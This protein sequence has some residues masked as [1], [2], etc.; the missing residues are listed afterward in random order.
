MSQ[1]NNVQPIKKKRI[2]APRVNRREFGGHGEGGDEHLWA[3]SYSDLL[4]VLMSFFVIYFSFDSGEKAKDGLLNIAVAMKGQAVVD[5]EKPKPKET[6]PAGINGE[7][8]KQFENMNLRIDKPGNALVI[9]LEPDIFKLGEF[10]LDHRTEERLKE[11]SDLIEPF[12]NSVDIVVIGHSDAAKVSRSK[13]QY[14][15]NNFDL[16]SLRALKALQY[17]LTLGFPNDQ[18]SAQG[19]AENI[20]SSRTISLRIQLRGKTT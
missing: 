14:M 5:S 3:V 2:P 17:M 19:A 13:N 16:S 12:K 8:R 20:R 4:M 10:K 18:I 6:I 9:Q 11:I 1:P 15:S 7:L